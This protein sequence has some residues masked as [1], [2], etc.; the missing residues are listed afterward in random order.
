MGGSWCAQLS[1]ARTG[2]W[3]DSLGRVPDGLAVAEPDEADL[4]DLLSTM[5]SPAGVLRYVRPPGEVNGYTP[6]WTTP[7]PSPGADPPAWW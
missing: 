1:L 7:P 4:A 3:L 5:D 6:Q 2:A